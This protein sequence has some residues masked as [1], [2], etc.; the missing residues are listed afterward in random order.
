MPN[1]PTCGAPVDAKLDKCPYCGA[2]VPNED[3]ISQNATKPQQNIIQ[4]T[5]QENPEA[6]AKEEKKIRKRMWGSLICVGIGIILY[7]MLYIFL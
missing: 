3:P 7:C 6:I 4:R 5:I 2:S 1:C